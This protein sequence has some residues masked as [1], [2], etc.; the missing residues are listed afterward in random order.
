MIF[1]SYRLKQ[2]Y[3]F[4]LTTALLTSCRHSKDV[5]VS[6]IDVTVTIDRFDKDVEAMRTQNR[7]KVAAELQKKYGPF[8]RDFMERIIQVGSL[9]DTGYLETFGEVLANQ[10]YNDV[11]H[12]VDSIYPNLDQQNQELTDAFKHIKYYY[13]Q[14]ELPKVYAYISGFG[15]QT[16]IGEGYVGISLDMF[17]GADSKFYNAPAIREVNP[18]YISRRFTPNHITPRIIETIAREDMF[19]ETNIDDKSMLSRMIYNGRILYFMDRVLPNMDDTLKMGYTGKQLKWCN[20]MRSQ[21][22]GYFLEEKLLYETDYDKIQKYLGESPFT[23]GLGDKNDSSPRLAVWTGWQIV[24]QYMDRHPEVTLPELMR[25][26]DAEKIL[27]ESKYR[28]E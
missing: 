15:V 5:D 27:R 17:L 21:I 8:Y 7:E 2:I 11:K 22:W 10:P 26:R 20:D 1:N 6:N 3:L 19:P 28:P 13:P 18:K 9:R 14:K 25:D 23:P 12:E 4:F 24:R 16:P